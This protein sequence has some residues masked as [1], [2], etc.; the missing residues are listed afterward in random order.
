MTD[1]PEDVV[2]TIDVAAC[3]K[4][5]EL[6]GAYLDSINVEF[7]GLN[8]EQ[9]AIFLTRVV[10]GAMMAAKVIDLHDGKPPF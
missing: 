7:P 3:L 5:G 2:Y 6:G 1:R 9:W 10:G 8:K 4:G